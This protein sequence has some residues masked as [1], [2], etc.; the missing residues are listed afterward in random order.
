MINLF[1]DSRI[2]FSIGGTGL[3][4]YLGLYNEP[5][6]DWDILTDEDPSIVEDCLKG[7]NYT[8]K[9]PSDSYHSE[10]L[11]QVNLDGIEFDIMCKFKYKFKGELISISS[12]PYIWKNNKPL[13]SPI[14]WQLFYERSNRSSKKD[15]KKSELLKK[16]INSNT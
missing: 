15:F 8:R 13:A 3:L 16:W 4:F 2:E 11:F 6:G 14:E 5:L 10:C 9:I 7:L 12:L 1:N